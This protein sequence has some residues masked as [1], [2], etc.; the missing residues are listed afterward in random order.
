MPAASYVL[1][2]SMGVMFYELRSEPLGAIDF[3]YHGDPTSWNQ[4]LG[5]WLLTWQH[6]GLP[7]PAHSTSPFDPWWDH[8]EGRDWADSSSVWARRGQARKPPAEP[9][10]QAGQGYTAYKRGSICPSLSEAA[11]SL[12][13]GREENELALLAPNSNTVK[14]NMALKRNPYF[15]GSQS[16][17]E[18]SHSQWILI[19]I[20]M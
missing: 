16:T 11:R 5:W 9:H 3:Q 10:R 19:K 2:P 8:S 18:Q 17:E 12:L 4:C 14:K 1:F 20:R 13:P 7:C 15:T 6:T